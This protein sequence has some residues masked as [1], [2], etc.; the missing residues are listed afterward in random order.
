MGLNVETVKLLWLQHRNGLLVAGSS[1]A[2]HVSNSASF[3]LKESPWV[4]ECVCGR[5]LK[6]HRACQSPRLQCPGPSPQGACHSS[7]SFPKEDL[8]ARPTDPGAGCLQRL[9]SCFS[10]EL[11]AL[12]VETFLPGD[13]SP[14]LV[15]LRTES[16]LKGS[17]FLTEGHS[18][19]SQSHVPD[20]TEKR[21]DKG[22][23]RQ[24][25]VRSE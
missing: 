5:R 21:K 20:H 12:G 1:E 23:G 7:P 9:L 24:K 3:F 22:E 13:L 4:Q 11:G 19:R 14:I 6:K 8:P 25:R 2:V 18:A 15:P 17:C 16:K 10:V